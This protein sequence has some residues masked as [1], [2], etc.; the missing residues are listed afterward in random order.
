MYWRALFHR[1]PE[2]NVLLNEG[3]ALAM[4]WGDHWLA[5]IDARLRER[6]RHLRPDQ[7]AELNAACQAVLRLGHETAHRHM[8]G[9]AEPPSV[10]SFSSLVRTNYPW[11][12]QENLARLFSQSLYYAAKTGA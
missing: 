4:D 11:V 7:L 9:S 8:R 3:L 10:E 5:P 6:H 1:V 2:Q 12:N